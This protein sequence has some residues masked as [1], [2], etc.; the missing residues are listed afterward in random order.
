MVGCV[1]WVRAEA[2]KLGKST[3]SDF[4]KKREEDNKKDLTQGESKIFFNLEN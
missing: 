1:E 4:K 3:N 2:R